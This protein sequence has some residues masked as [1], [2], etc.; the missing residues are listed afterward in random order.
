METSD[1][2][3]AIEPNSRWQN[4]IIITSV[5]IP[6]VVAILIYLPYDARIASLD[7][8]FLPHLNAFLNSATALSLIV[9]LWAILNKKVRTH[10]MANITAFVLSSIFLISYVVFHYAAPPTL[11]GDLNHD[12]ILSD[13]E[14]I[15]A[16][17]RGMY[18]GLLLSHILL[19]AGVVPLVLFSMYYSLSGQFQKHRRL[20]RITWPIWFYVA[21]TG[22]VVYALI[23][24][25]YPS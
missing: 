7:V 21:V 9:S 5:L 15:V 22:V 20:S 11:Y 1:Y 23:S 16:T 12:G 8:S 2:A 3:R 4:V 25:Y 6:I 19:A 14:R 17:G 13:G 24:P 10:K 18:I